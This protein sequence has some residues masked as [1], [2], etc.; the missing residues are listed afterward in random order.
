[1]QYVV[2][3]S[4]KSHVN[5]YMSA[6]DPSDGPLAYIRNPIYTIS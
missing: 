2:Q 6:L 4:Q 3:T 1:M 5:D